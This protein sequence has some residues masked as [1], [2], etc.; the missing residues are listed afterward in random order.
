MF[1]RALLWLLPITILLFGCQHAPVVI[2]ADC[3]IPASLDYEAKGPAQL[4]V[5]LTPVDKLLP[6]LI[7]NNKDHGLLARDY[8]D[9]VGH[10]K[11]ECQ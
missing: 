7:Q 1:R 9:L 4:E 6:P 8:N 3:E 5:R 10:V 11:R 2:R